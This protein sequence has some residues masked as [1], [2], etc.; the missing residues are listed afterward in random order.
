MS[1]FLPLAAFGERVR[2]P[3]WTGIYEGNGSIVEFYFEAVE[4]VKW[5]K[6]TSYRMTAGLDDNFG[7]L[8]AATGW[9][10]KYPWF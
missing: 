8:S 7:R 10:V 1:F 2:Y 3:H 9:V 6:A 5:V 4:P